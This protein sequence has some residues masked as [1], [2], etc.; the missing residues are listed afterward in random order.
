MAANN[1]I[2]VTIAN[3]YLTIKNVTNPNASIENYD[4]SKVTSVNEYYQD[5]TAINAYQN[6]R[7]EY[8]EEFS[9]LIDLEENP[10]SL[11]KIQFDIQNVTNQAG[12][13]IDRAGLAQ[14]TADIIA[15]VSAVVGGG[16]GSTSYTSLGT[17][18]KVVATAGTAETLVA[19]STPS[20]LVTITALSSNTDT[21]VIGGAS[22]VA[23]IGTRQGTPLEPGDSV[24]SSI[25]DLQKLYV[26]SVVNG[27]GVSFTYYN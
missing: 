18:R 6:G 27:E 20:L 12:W 3:G 4:L 10:E 21:V 7:H 1:Q 15:A 9:V 26:D 25:D 13:T 17:G 19:A 24:D 8:D 22:V 16:G 14:A 5:Y 2:E 23:A 11:I